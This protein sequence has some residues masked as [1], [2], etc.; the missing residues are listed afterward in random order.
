MCNVKPTVTPL[1]TWKNILTLLFLPDSSARV[2]REYL[3]F[4]ASPCYLWHYS[5]WLCTNASRIS[6][7]FT[8]ESSICLSEKMSIDAETVSRLMLRV[9]WKWFSIYSSLTKKYTLERA[10]IWTRLLND[11][12]SFGLAPAA[13]CVRHTESGH[14]VDEKDDG[15][16][17]THLHDDFEQGVGNTTTTRWQK[18]LSHLK[19]CK[20]RRLKNWSS[21]QG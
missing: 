9:G 18:V 7:C 10:R 6:I 4:Y 2:N 13:G 16:H 12:G 8:L 5:F 14:D 17:Q 19:R 3:L 11:S 15:C 1:G 20:G 21:V